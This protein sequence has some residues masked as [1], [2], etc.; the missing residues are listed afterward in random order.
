MVKKLS[1]NDIKAFFP[2]WLN[3]ESEKKNVLFMFAALERH[4]SGRQR[5]PA[6]DAGDFSEE[7][8]DFGI[9]NVKS[10]ED[11]KA[12]AWGIWLDPKNWIRTEKYKYWPK[13]EK[14]C[15]GH[16]IE[17]NGEDVHWAIEKGM[18]S[19]DGQKLDFEIDFYGDFD[20]EALARACSDLNRVRDCTIRTFIP[21][22]T[23]G[24]NF[25]LFVLTSP[26]DTEVIGWSVGQD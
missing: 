22:N 11:L 4:E 20:K 5:N 19:G 26:D 10:V 9:K 6:W 24:E 17:I 8:A 13:K 18:T 12:K 3:R 1:T 14:Y 21:K 7:E 23:F 25:S 16:G 2:T 15:N